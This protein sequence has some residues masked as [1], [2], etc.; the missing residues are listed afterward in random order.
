[1][2]ILKAFN[3]FI[4]LILCLA[5][6]LSSAQIGN[7]SFQTDY[8]YFSTHHFWNKSGKKRLAHN[9]F[10]LREG[11]A[12]A[13]YSTDDD[14]LAIYGAWDEIR[15]SLNGNTYGLADFEVSWTHKIYES[16][17]G[18]FYAQL[19]GIIPSGKKKDSLRY[20][21]IG[22]EGGLLYLVPFDFLC[23]HHSAFTRLGYR[24]YQG[25]PSD[26]VRAES[27]IELN[28]PG[29]L[30]A[31]ASGS[32][33]YGLFNAHKSQHPNEIFYNPNYR[34]FKIDLQLQ[35]RLNK[36][37]LLNGGAFR[38]VWGKNIGTGT[39]VFGGLTFE[40]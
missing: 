23:G 16:E 19:V 14:L 8:L 2:K 12:W 37:L 4:T 11:N 15:E 7:I 18:D 10:S 36:Y 35:A 38:H 6:P 5:S 17:I 26:Q 3:V 29:G 13:M 25:D 22:V 27:G 20:G 30:L 24:F 40:F 21:E 39:G 1:M 9:H 28:L 31:K 34:L 32:L 33:E